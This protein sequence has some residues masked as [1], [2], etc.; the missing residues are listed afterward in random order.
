MLIHANTTASHTQ[1]TRAST[2]E[3]QDILNEWSSYDNQVMTIDLGKKHVE[4]ILG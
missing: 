2:Q 4:R 1:M 3:M